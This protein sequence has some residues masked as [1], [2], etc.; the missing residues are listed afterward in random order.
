MNTQDVK[1]NGNG[2]FT[3]G[4]RNGIPVLIVASCRGLPYLNYMHAYNVICGERFRLSFVSPHEYA[5]L[6]GSGGLRETIGRVEEDGAALQTIRECQIFIHEHHASYGLFNTSRLSTKNIYQFGMDPRIDI[7]IP[8]FND[9]FLLSED[10]MRYDPPE[11]EETLETVAD[12]NLA[13]F[14]NA[15]GKTSFPSFAQWFLGTY[16]K[17]RLFW[18]FNHVSSAFTLEVFRRM[19][20]EF[21]RL[22]TTQAF[23]DEISSVDLFYSPATLYTQRDR[24][25]LGY[26]WEKD[27]T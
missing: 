4:P 10:I 20:D 18:T 15:C 12:L 8:N 25:E 5:F 2:F 7:S 21:L 3:V 26:R 22:P 9:V 11:G 13:R 23:W 19:N 6:G 17:T 1:P 27:F 16:K 24:D 14:M